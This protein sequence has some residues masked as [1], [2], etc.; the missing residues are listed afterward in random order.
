MTSTV[1]HF[2]SGRD[3]IMSRLNYFLSNEQV[4]IEE[5]GADATGI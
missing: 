4:L 3:T 2:L 5:P 1:M